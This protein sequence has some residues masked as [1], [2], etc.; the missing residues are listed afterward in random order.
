M[1]GTLRPCARKLQTSDRAAL[2]VVFSDA[3]AV[4]IEALR[5][6]IANLR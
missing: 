6:E 3:A 2:P 1:S 5:K 4:D